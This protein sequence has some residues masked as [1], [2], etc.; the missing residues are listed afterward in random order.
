MPPSEDTGSGAT[1]VEDRLRALGYLA[2]D[3]S[4][5]RGEAEVYFRTIHGIPAG[6]TGEAEF[7]RI[8]FS[9]EDACPAPRPPTLIDSD[10]VTNQ[11]RFVTRAFTAGN[12][13]EQEEAL[14]DGL[15][16]YG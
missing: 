3:G 1:P 16:T 5:D 11:L 14:A 15:L 9:D 13:E 10:E 6:A 4:Q 2:A 12:T 8:L 7:Q